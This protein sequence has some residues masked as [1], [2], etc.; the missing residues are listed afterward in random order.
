MTAVRLPRNATAT[1]SLA[2]AFEA[3]VTA[4]QS[5]IQ[6]WAAQADAIGYVLDRMPLDPRNGDDLRVAV[7]RGVNGTRAIVRWRDEVHYGITVLDA[8]A[9]LVQAHCYDDEA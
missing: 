4:R 2:R 8:L 5:G 9:Q 3:L 1:L 7:V 6:T